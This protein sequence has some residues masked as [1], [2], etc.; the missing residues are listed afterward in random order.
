MI[1]TEKF[2]EM[3]PGAQLEWNGSMYKDYTYRSTSCIHLARDIHRASD[4][5]TV[6]SSHGLVFSMISMYDPNAKCCLFEM[7][8]NSL[9]SV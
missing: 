9:F 6:H 4:K 8:E 5:K 2:Q 3:G 1:D 7:S